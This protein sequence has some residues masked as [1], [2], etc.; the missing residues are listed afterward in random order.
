MSD[1][2]R[3]IGSFRC[4][5]LWCRVDQPFDTVSKFIVETSPL[6]VA[7][8]LLR[9]I[10]VPARVLRAVP[11]RTELGRVAEPIDNLLRLDLDGTRRRR[12][13]LLLEAM[14]AWQTGYARNLR[15]RW[16]NARRKRRPAIPVVLVLK[17]GHGR[18]TMPRRGVL[19]S[20]AMGFAVE[21]F[22]YFVVKLWEI[23]A[24]DLLANGP[25]AALPFLPFAGGASTEKARAGFTRLRDSRD[26]KRND[27]IVA[28]AINSAHVFPGVDW[29]GTIPRE[30]R[31]KNPVIEQL[32]A[33]QIRMKNPLIEQILAEQVRMNTPVIER[34]RAEFEAKGRTDTMREMA[35][36]WMRA[37]FGARTASPLV[38]RLRT[39]S[40]PKLTRATDLLA[41][42]KDD[43]AL[44]GALKKLL[45]ARRRE[46]KRR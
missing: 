42:T 34:I 38:A 6:G 3:T 45:P 21:A 13:W 30:V 16:E 18:T 5:R 19:A 25:L 26:R 41:T 40:E 31:M 33:E 9:R 11:D 37:R 4:P 28:L 10:G 36:R 32:V 44:L 24:D 46:S 43:A 29:L 12:G 1:L 17:K 39:A 35:V 14:A 27:L 23:P 8:F 22:R 20:R 7:R 15:N 2:G